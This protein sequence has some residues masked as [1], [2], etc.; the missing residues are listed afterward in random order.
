MIRQMLPE[1]LKKLYNPSI[2]VENQSYERG[3]VTNEAEARQ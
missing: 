2:F 3:A 1:E